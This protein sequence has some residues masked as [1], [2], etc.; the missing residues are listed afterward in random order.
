MTI[1]DFAF[2]L[3]GDFNHYTWWKTAA[4]GATSN[5]PYPTF[6]VI[7]SPLTDITSGKSPSLSGSSIFNITSTTQNT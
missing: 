7:I 6:G 3:S 4:N 5:A 2:D 1:V